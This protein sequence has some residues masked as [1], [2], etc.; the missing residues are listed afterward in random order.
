MKLDKK[1]L[2]LTLARSKMTVQSV[3]EKAGVSKNTIAGVFARCSCKPM[4]AGTIA[5]ALGVDVTEIMKTED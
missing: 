5:E 1:K 4:T 2:E 3:A